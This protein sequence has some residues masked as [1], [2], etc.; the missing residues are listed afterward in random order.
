M[1]GPTAPG[2]PPALCRRDRSPYYLFSVLSPD[3]AEPPLLL[4]NLVSGFKDL[5]SVF[6]LCALCSPGTGRAVPS[7]T[8]FFLPFPSPLASL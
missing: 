8:F 5:P 7:H 1:T 2:S 4:L 3:Q 6:V